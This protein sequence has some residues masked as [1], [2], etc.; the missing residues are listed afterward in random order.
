[1]TGPG[2]CEIRHQRLPD[3]TKIG[4]MLLTA[5]DRSERD[6]VGTIIQV[7]LDRDTDHDVA[8]ARVGLI[9]ERRR[10]AVYANKT[11]SQ[12]AVQRK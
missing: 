11:R 6:R 10:A 7:H 4:T 3:E 8:A 1:M 5:L 9:D 2:A 12:L